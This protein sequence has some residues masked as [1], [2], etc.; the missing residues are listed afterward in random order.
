LSIKLKDKIIETLEDYDLYEEDLY[1]PG[2]DD[3]ENYSSHEDTGTESSSTSSS[4]AK[5]S[6]FYEASP[7]NVSKL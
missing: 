1:G 5:S 7:K 4:L 6:N 3:N 2:E